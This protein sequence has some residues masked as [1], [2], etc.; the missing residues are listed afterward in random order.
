M[1]F[2]LMICRRGM[3]IWARRHEWPFRI[4][5][6]RESRRE[7]LP[8][9]RQRKHRKREWR[10]VEHAARTVTLNSGRRYGKADAARSA[11]ITQ[12]DA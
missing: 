10:K 7:L 5:L 2:I 12:R 4:V 11:S 3:K 9:R 6:K 8:R 1:K